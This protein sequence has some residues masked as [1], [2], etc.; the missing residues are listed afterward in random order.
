MPFCLPKA[1]SSYPAGR[2]ILQLPKIDPFYIP[3]NVGHSHMVTW[4]IVSKG[5]RLNN[6]LTSTSRRLRSPIG[7]ACKVKGKNTNQPKH[8]QPHDISSSSWS[9]GVSSSP[10]SLLGL[11]LHL[12][13]LSQQNTNRNPRKALEFLEWVPVP[14]VP[15]GQTKR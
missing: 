5:S 3:K 8:D 4:N 2:V 1:A 15:P 7:S 12:I 13:D 14:L 10:A 11:L 9:G 6:K